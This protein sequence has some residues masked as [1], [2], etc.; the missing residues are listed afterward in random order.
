M[1]TAARVMT[2]VIPTIL[3]LGAGHGAVLAIV[4]WRRARNR[5]ANRYLAALLAALSL[6][7][8]EGARSTSVLRLAQPHLIGVVAWL[9]FVLGPLTFLYVRAMT[10]PASQS[11]PSPRRHFAVAAAFLILLCVT[12]FPRSAEYKLWVQATAPWFNLVAGV[13]ILVHGFAYLVAAMVLLGRHPSRVQSLYSDLTGIGLRWLRVLVGLHAAIW[14]IALALF[15]VRATGHAA[16]LA[17][18]A[19]ASVP[20]GSTLLVFLAGYFQ[21]GQV[22]IFRDRPDEQAEPARRSPASIA[23]PDAEPAASTPAPAVAAVEPPGVIASEAIAP[24]VPGEPV[25]E[26]ASQEPASPYRRARLSDDEADQLVSRMHASMSE[27]RL[28]RRPGLTLAELAEAVGATPHEVSQVLSVR[29]GRNF[30]T[31]VNEHRV[32][33]AKAALVAESHQHASVL[34]IAFEAGFRSKSTFNAA[35]RSATGV[36]PSAFRRAHTADR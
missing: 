15:V 22:E 13:A 19:G 33:H 16:A 1:V 5:R 6:L 29:L 9:P 30:Y 28:Y 27:A 32:A 24:P 23:E 2:G 4:L 21:L 25:S 14:G 17:H 12:F 11:L 26:P 7:M 10:A 35:F 31:F 36:T 18:A 20:L 34:D 3:L 8:L